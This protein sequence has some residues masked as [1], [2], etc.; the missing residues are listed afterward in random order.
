MSTIYVREMQPIEYSTRN[1]SLGLP[2]GPYNLDKETVESL[3]EAKKNG[4]YAIGYIAPIGG[5]VP[6]II[7]SSDKDLQKEILKKI[8][9][10][11]KKGYN[12][13]CFKYVNSS[14]ERF[15]REC[16]NFH[17]FQKQLDNK[18]HPLPPPGTN[19]SCPDRI[20][21]K[22]FHSEKVTN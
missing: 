13:F 4:N 10:A 1:P 16:L 2:N 17:T 22:F 8:E 6:K 21:A 15:E 7:G 3:I 5:F 12:K 14:K 18:N 9:I 20:C 11:I 19:Y